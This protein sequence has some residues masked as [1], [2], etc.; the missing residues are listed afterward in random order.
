MQAGA[1][2]KYV[3]ICNYGVSMHQKQRQLY[4]QNAFMAEIRLKDYDYL[5]TSQTDAI[6]F[7]TVKRLIF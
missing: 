1:S 7:R 5:Y 3:C 6:Y 4:Y 2:C